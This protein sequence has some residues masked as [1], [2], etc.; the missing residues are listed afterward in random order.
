MTNQKIDV[1]TIL[2]KYKI[3]SDDSIYIK[4]GD[5]EYVLTEGRIRELTSKF[6]ELCNIEATKYHDFGM[7]AKVVGLLID[8]KKSWWPATQKSLTANVDFD[9]QLDKWFEIQ[10]QLLEKEKGEVVVEVIPNDQ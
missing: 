2:Q 9:K 6:L 8:I 10:K 5:E 1:D 3:T 7:N 4:T